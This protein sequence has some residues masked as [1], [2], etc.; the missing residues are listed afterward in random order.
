MGMLNKLNLRRHR[1]TLRGLDYENMPAD[2]MQEEGTTGDGRLSNTLYEGTR[3]VPTAEEMAERPGSASQPVRGE[4][5]TPRAQW[6]DAAGCWVEWSAE[7]DDWV[8]VPG[9]E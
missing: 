1:G 9:A 6:D 3:R 7:V 4:R 8:P 2:A 5:P